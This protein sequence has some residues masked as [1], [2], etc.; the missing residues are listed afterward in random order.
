MYIESSRERWTEQERE[1]EYEVE[2]NKDAQRDKER[3]SDT[4]QTMSCGWHKS[5]LLE[6]G[7]SGD[8]FHSL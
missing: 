8:I 1:R 6:R 3:H 4:T 2:R 7:E 5:T